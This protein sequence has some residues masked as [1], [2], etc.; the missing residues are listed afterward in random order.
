MTQL[1]GV[2]WLKVNVTQPASHVLGSE[3]GGTERVDV[4]LIRL[5]PRFEREVILQ[6]D[7]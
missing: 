7:S 3:I 4:G 1:Q 6:S 2:D 5:N